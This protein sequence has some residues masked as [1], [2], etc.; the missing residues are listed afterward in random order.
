MYIKYFQVA[1]TAP[2]D[3]KNLITLE[4]L[5]IIFKNGVIKGKTLTSFIK[6]ITRKLLVRE[7]PNVAFKLG[8]NIKGFN[9][10]CPFLMNCN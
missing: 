9:Q 3:F 2:N 5:R 7:G 10:L 6:E 1:E 4:K 8:L